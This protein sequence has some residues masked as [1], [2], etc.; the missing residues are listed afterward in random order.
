VEEGTAAKAADA[1]QEFLEHLIDAGPTLMFRERLPD[2]Q[3]TYASRNFERVLGFH[4]GQVHETPR[5]FSEQILPADRSRFEAFAAAVISGQPHRRGSDFELVD[6][7][8]DRRWFVVDLAL[9]SANGANY[10]LGHAADVTDRVRAERA[11]NEAVERYQAIFTGVPSGIFRSAPNGEI[12][13]ANRMLAEIFGYASVD[14]LKRE[15]P[16]VGAVYLDRQDRLRFIESVVTDG[17]V[18]NFET[19]IRRRTGEVIDVSINASVVRDRDGNVLGFEGT[20][21]DVTDQRSAEENARRAWAEADRANQAKS[22]FL[23]RMSHELRT[24]LNSIIGFAQL[25]ELRQPEPEVADSVHH[26]SKAGRHLLEL[27]NEILDIAK[28]EAGRIGLSIE[29]VRLGEVVHETIA[30][31]RPLAA[32]RSISIGYEG[33]QGFD[34]YVRADRQRL[35]QV[36][37][38]L[39]SNAV[40][41]NL[42][43]GSV[44]ITSTLDD[45][46]VSVAVTDTG[47]GIKPEQME[48]LFVP[49]ER[50]GAEASSEEGTGLGLTLSQNLTEAMGGVLEVS[51]TYREGST[52][53]LILPSSLAPLEMPGVAMAI[54]DPEGARAAVNLHSVLYIEDNLASISLVEQILALRPGLSLETAMQGRLGVSLAREHRPDLILLDLNLADVSGREVLAELKVD[55]RT[56]P[57]PVLM[58]SADA[59]PGQ[60]QRLLDGG[61]AGYLTKPLD[62]PQFL[63]E[64]DRLLQ[65]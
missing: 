57:I 60:I 1:G 6:A 42:E 28:V 5:F 27:I 29:P 26:I 25:I 39:L 33:D 24:P 13:E 64:V 20:L 3:V 11:A 22:V 19:K 38:N 32:A 43:G 62:V 14:E 4:P 30:L 16:H 34:T 21:V 55:P 45:G 7:A 48:R 35:K 47:P 65:L 44:V 15:V 53:T 23:S 51:S 31:I 12:L 56:Q 50:L 54:S 8:G 17:S 58:I 46:F 9:Q 61:A 37:L 10:L 36:M 59:S 63:G 18:Q 40:K 49:F 52:F 41:Y 2:R